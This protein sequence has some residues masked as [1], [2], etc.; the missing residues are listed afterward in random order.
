MGI[1]LV[2]LPPQLGFS[3]V[4]LVIMFLLGIY[5]V[6]HL[7]EWMAQNEW[8]LRFTGIIVWGALIISFGMSLWPKSVLAFHAFLSGGYEPAQRF[9]NVD[10][11]IY[12]PPEDAIQN[13][14]L[15]IRGIPTRVIKSI[16]QM[17]TGAGDCQPKPVPLPDLRM[18]IRGLDGRD[19]YT[20]DT[21]DEAADENFFL[22]WTVR[23]PRIDGHT[24]V[25]VR[26][27]IE[28]YMENDGISTMGNY[29]LIPSKGSTKVDVEETIPINKS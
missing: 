20:L 3:I 29:E 22:E 14:D 16:V 11:D 5:P 12:N 28:G 21:Q 25:R 10:M 19:A 23:C 4:W 24:N 6:L 7:V 13:L 2:F 17:P 27:I 15:T 26:L 1:I 9:I 8:L 18:V